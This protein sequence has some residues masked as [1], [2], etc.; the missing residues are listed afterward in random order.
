MRQAVKMMNGC[1]FAPKHNSKP[2][3]GTQV[4]GSDE[5][6]ATEMESR[7]GGKRATKK[8]LYDR[9]GGIFVIANL[10]DHFSDAVVAN[11][12]VGVGSPNEYLDDW[13]RNRQD[14]LPGLKWMRTLWLAAAAGGPYRY[15][16]TRAGRCPMSLENAHASLLISPKEFDEV[17]AELGRSLDHFKVPGREKSEVLAAF[18]AHKNEVDRS[19]VIAANGVVPPVRCV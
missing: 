19:F 15:V 16:A 7:T 18:A 12:K 17:A 5:G 4:H 8:S 13:S 14:R 2:E 10:V 9:L 1:P 3:K 6:K 11:R